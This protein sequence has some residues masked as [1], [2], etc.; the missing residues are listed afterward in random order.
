MLNESIF[1]QLKRF[2]STKVKVQK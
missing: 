1:L 2:K